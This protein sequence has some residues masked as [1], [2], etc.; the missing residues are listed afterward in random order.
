MR[1]ETMAD[2]YGIDTDGTHIPADARFRT[3]RGEASDYAGALDLLDVARLRASEFARRLDA[4]SESGGMPDSGLAER[5]ELA[6]A[7]ID[8]LTQSLG[9]ATRTRDYWIQVAQAP[10]ALNDSRLSDAWE[11]AGEIATEEGFCAEYDR[12]CERIG[13]PGRERDWSVPVD[14]SMTFNV[15]VRGRS[16]SDAAERIDSEVAAETMQSWGSQWRFTDA[17]TD[18][19]PDEDG[20]EID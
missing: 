14:V 12:M 11:R 7:R 15:I 1:E 18:V 4:I 13:I 3:L 20:A 2:Y 16:A 5:M 6:Q 8:E 19:T 9:E 10:I 17:I